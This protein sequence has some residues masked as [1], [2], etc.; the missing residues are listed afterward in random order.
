MRRIDQ[1]P[2]FW[3]HIKG[4]DKQAAKSNVP[5]RLATGAVLVADSASVHEVLSH[6]E[7]YVEESA[8]LRTRSF[9]PL[10]RQARADVISML[11][12][13]IDTHPPTWA[14]V[15][16]GDL[17]TERWLRTQSWGIRLMRGMYRDALAHDRGEAVDRVIDDYVERKTIRDDLFG[18]YRRMGP[19]ERDDLHMR[20]GRELESAVRDPREDDLFGKLANFEFPF[21]TIEK[22]ELFLRLVQSTVAFTGA[23]VEMAVWEAS[24]KEERKRAYA[25]GSSKSEVRELLRIFPIAWRVT[26]TVKEPHSLGD[27]DL[28]VDDE[29]IISAATVHRTDPS[30]ERPLEF[31]ASRWHDPA[32]MRSRAYLPFGRGPGMCPGRNVAVDVIEHALGH[33]YGLH[34]V[35]VRRTAWPRPYVRSVLSAPTS[36]IKLTPRE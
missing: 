20:M 1:R 33:I 32:V 19:A 7:L 12:T 24:G 4:W 25:S 26:R 22:G 23:A 14:Q 6:S 15:H 10:P 17:P 9:T 36:R 13:S 29:L 35:T 11:M 18:Q 16:P 31:D 3:T 28:K 8:F 34:D 27:E 5:R 30:W 2:S 21:P